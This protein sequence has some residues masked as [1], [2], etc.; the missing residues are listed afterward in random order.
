MDSVSLYLPTNWRWITKQSNSCWIDAVAVEYQF[1]QTDRCFRWLYLY[2]CCSQM[3]RIRLTKAFGF[4]LEKM[5]KD[6]ILW[7]PQ[8]RIRWNTLPPVRFKCRSFKVSV[9]ARESRRKETPSI[10]VRH[11]IHCRTVIEKSHPMAEEDVLNCRQTQLAFVPE[12]TDTSLHPS[13]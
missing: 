2:T 9:E 7:L 12:L 6:K 10:G 13:R 3:Y 5:R 11:W 1:A 4:E 8:V